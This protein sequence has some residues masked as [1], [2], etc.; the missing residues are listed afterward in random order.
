MGG[1]CPD[2]LLK[3]DCGGVFA[4]ATTDGQGE[5]TSCRRARMVPDADRSAQQQDPRKLFS[6]RASQTCVFG[7]AFVC[8]RVTTACT[9][10]TP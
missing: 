5:A 6:V 8:V 4:D 1:Q 7:C 10:A 2:Q 3:T 9:W